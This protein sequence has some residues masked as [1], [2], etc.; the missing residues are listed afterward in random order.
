MSEE[1]T[2]FTVDDITVQ[3]GTLSELLSEDGETFVSTLTPSTNTADSTNVLTITNTAYTDVAG[4][5]GTSTTNSDNYVVSTRV[6]SGGGG[7]GG[8]GGGSSRTA[9]PDPVVTTPESDDEDDTDSSD[10]FPFT[11]STAHWARTFIETLYDDGVVNGRT[12][13]TYAPDDRLTR[14]E[15][16]KIALELFGYE[17]GGSE[18]YPD[19]SS[20]D[21]FYKYVVAGT[22]LGVVQG[23]PDGSFKPNEAVTRAEALKILILASGKPYAGAANSP[24]ADVPQTA[25]FADFVDYAY[26]KGVVSGK[27]PTTFAP[28]DYI[29]RAEMAKIAVK[30]SEL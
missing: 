30:T 17:E 29:T 15:I 19:V 3:N 27:T 21:W 5:T 4:N 25:W 9:T 11:D 20:S 13:N 26:A 6:S 18:N 14:A 23:Y 7:G 8:G 22:K 16:L 1:V 24:F 10:S 12:E 2:G 28:N